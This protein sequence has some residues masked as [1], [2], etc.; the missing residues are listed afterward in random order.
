[1]WRASLRLSVA[2][3]HRKP[4]DESRNSWTKT[5][6][7]KSLVYHDHEQTSNQK[8]I[9]CLLWAISSELSIR[10]VSF[11]VNQCVHRLDSTENFQNESNWRFED[12]ENDGC[13]GINKITRYL[14]KKIT[15]QRF[16]AC[17]LLRNNDKKIDNEEQIVFVVDSRSNSL[18]RKTSSH[19]KNKMNTTL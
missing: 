14:F 1:M 8:K 16:L 7:S 15:H 6:N 3:R 9:S 18:Q 4:L 5:N 11:C 10:F 17:Y 2:A 12:F 19:T 13:T